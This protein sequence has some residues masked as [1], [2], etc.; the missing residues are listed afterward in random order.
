MGAYRNIKN[1]VKQE[2]F[3]MT[4]KYKSIDIENYSYIDKIDEKEIIIFNE[5]RKIIIRG[6]SLSINKLLNNEI[7]II[8][9]IEVINLEGKIE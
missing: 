9:N 1:Y 3:K 6:K 2:D 8:G 7:L 4:V 5:K